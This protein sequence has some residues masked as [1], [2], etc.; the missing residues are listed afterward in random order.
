VSNTFNLDRIAASR[1]L[2]VSLRTIDRYMAT[3]KL[4]HIKSRGRV[5]LSKEEILKLAKEFDNP[6]NNKTEAIDMSEWKPT[7]ANLPDENVIFNETKNKIFN[8][9]FFKQEPKPATEIKTATTDTV[10]IDKL[11]TQITDLKSEL[12]ETK[13]KYELTKEKLTEVTSK[14][15]QSQYRIGQLESQ[16]ATMVPLFEFQKQQEMVQRQQELT[17]KY[18]IKLKQQTTSLLE[19]IENKEIQLKQLSNEV[20]SERFNKAIFASLVFFILILQP[21]LWVLLK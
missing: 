13:K 2:N 1:L 17:Q 21:V 19:E 10:E 8:T 16:M 18:A 15:E 5:W 11:T 20:E 14:L 3:G 6:D 12:N 9:D 7:M 4:S